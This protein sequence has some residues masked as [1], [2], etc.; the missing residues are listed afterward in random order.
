MDLEKLAIEGDALQEKGDLDG[1]IGVWTGALR[2]LPDPA[3]EDPL[4]VWFL[5]S[6]GDAQ[7]E[8]GRFLEAVAAT[9]QALLAGGADT[10]FVWLRRGQSLVEL[11]DLDAGVEALTNGFMLEGEAIFEDEDP[12]YEALLRERGIIPDE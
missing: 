9:G 8:S 11:G 2:H 7:F 10:G 5:A 1:A 6:I 3:V 12:K 4:S